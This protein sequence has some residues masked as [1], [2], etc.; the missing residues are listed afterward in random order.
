MT[1]A[2]QGRWARHDFRASLPDAR[3]AV[4][5]DLQISQAITSSPGAGPA[6]AESRQQ[7]GSAVAGLLSVLPS[8]PAP[9][10]RG[11]P[12]LPPHRPSPDCERIDEPADHHDA[13]DQ[14]DDAVDDCPFDDLHNVIHHVADDNHHDHDHAG[15]TAV[16]HAGVA[17]L[18][19]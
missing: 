4:N 13:C 6:T 11:P 2:V 9:L 8:S 17:Q 19:P 14:H 5:G 12:D 18:H 16:Q 1:L 7:A 10:H 3:T 15:G